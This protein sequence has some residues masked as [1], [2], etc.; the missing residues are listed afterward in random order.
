MKKTFNYVI[1]VLSIIVYMILTV[2]QGRGVF[3][4]YMNGVT[5]QIQTLLIILMT[6][7]VGKKGFIASLVVSAFSFITVVMGLVRSGNMSSLPGAFIA[8]VTMIMSYIIYNYGSKLE[9]ANEELQ[10]SIDEIN[11]K[12]NELTEKDKKLTY[13]AYNDVLTGLPNRHSLI[14]TM[15]KKISDNPRDSFVL[16]NMAIDNFREINDVLGHNAGDE[17]IYTFAQRIKKACGDKCFVATLS[18]HEFAVVIDGD[19]EKDAVNDLVEKIRQ[20]V[21]QPFNLMG[22]TVQKTMSYGAVKYPTD[23]FN[24]DELIKK[25]TGALDFAKTLGGNMLYLYENNS[26]TNSQNVKSVNL[27]SN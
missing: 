3:P 11:A 15:E 1:L 12:N 13:L 10:N 4:S 21:N 26:K 17:T 16:L 2:I 19:L 18:G 7:K 6:V 24:T 23:T 8:I 20:E 5:A 25:S 22:T 14:E 27:N 9:S